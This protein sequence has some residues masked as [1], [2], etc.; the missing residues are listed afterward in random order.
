M[1][2]L[3]VLEH[4]HPYI[5]GAENLFRQLTKELANKGFRVTVITSKHHKSLASIEHIDN[6]SIC[7]VNCFNRYFFTLM[8]LPKIF[9]ESRH[10]DLIHTTTYTAALPAWIIGCIRKK[11]TVLTFHEVWGDLWFS[12]PFAKKWSKNLFYWFEQMLLRISFDHYI[13]VSNYTRNCLIRHHIPSHK[14]SR[15]YNGLSYEEF[16]EA[17]PNVPTHFTFTFMGRLGISKGID[18]LL[19]AAAIFKKKYPDSIFQFIIPKQPS[20]LFKIVQKRIK[21][22]DLDNWMKIKHELTKDELLEAMRRSSVIVIPSYSEGFCFVAA[23]ASALR[24]PIISSRMGSLPEVVSGSFIEMKSLSIEA[25][26]EAL[27]SAKKKDWKQLP[28]KHFLLSE[29]IKQH[30]NLYQKLIK[31]NTI[32]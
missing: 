8:S 19:P 32:K 13:A 26:A 31:Q 1:S 15:I 3:F 17:K 5:G 10:C 24:I 28:V 2:I 18:L 20:S 21:S 25:L 30:M 29:T 11:P 7:R 16:S 12:L 22:L 9:K 4:F 23:E 27:I 6:V 14:I